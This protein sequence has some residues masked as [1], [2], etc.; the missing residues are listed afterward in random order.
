[1]EQLRQKLHED[2]DHDVLSSK[3]DWLKAEPPIRGPRFEAQVYLKKDVQAKAVKQ[4]RLQGERLEARKEIAMGWCANGRAEPSSSNWRHPSF[5]V[6][7][8]DGKWR[9][10]I[11]LKWLNSQ[12]EDDAYPL[13]RIE[14]LLVRQAKSSCFTVMDLKDALHQMPLS[15]QC[16]K[17]ADSTPERKAPL[18]CSSGR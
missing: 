16:T 15:M 17:T 6:K 1:M 12:C 14:D 8:K 3:F 4:I 13:P 5:P 2:Y 7:R 9:G 11:D 18:V 10:V